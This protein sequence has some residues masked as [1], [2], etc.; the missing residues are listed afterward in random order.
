ML[1]AEKLEAMVKLGTANSRMKDFFDI[2]MLLREQSFT[3]ARLRRAI[4][5]TFERR[6]TG[7]PEGLPPALTEAFLRDP[8]KIKLWKAFLHRIRLSDDHVELEIVGSAIA[9]FV[10][11][12][13][14]EVTGAHSNLG[15][16]PLAGWKQKEQ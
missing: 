1:I 9:A 11:P 5:A 16:Q 10:M 6:K 4:I 7:L 2:W 14:D 3:M 13:I 15:W 8:G 12:V